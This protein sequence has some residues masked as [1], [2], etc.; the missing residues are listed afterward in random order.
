MNSSERR[1]N[2]AEAMEEFWKRNYKCDI[3]AMRPAARFEDAPPSIL[4]GDPFAAPQRC[5]MV[6]GINPKWQGN[7]HIFQNEIGRMRGYHPTGFAE[8]HLWRTGYFCGA[9]YYGRYFTRLGTA[10]GRSFR[11]AS[12]EHARR[13]RSTGWNAGRWLFDTHAVKFDLLPWWSRNVSGFDFRALAKSEPVA[14]WKAVITAF[15]EERKPAAI[16]VNGC[17]QRQLVEAFFDTSLKRVCGFEAWTGSW[18]DTPILVHRQLNAPGGLGHDR[19]VAMVKASGLRESEVA[20]SEL[21]PE[22]SLV[23]RHERRAK[24]GGTV[25]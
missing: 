17:G 5:I 18:S 16:V 20:S 22:G 10:L 7:G 6:L 23:G 11:S 21:N 3:E 19:Y 14:S 2:F 1:I 9:L 4:T 8:Y 15:V 13:K 24:S 25:Y 12:L